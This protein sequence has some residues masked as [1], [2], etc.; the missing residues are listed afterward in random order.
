MPLLSLSM[1]LI[2]GLCLYVGLQVLSQFVLNRHSWSPDYRDL[3]FAFMSLMVVGYSGSELVAYHSQDVASYVSAFRWRGVFGALLLG[4]WPWFVYRYT[5]A[6]P[7]AVVWTLSVYFGLN[8]IVHLLRPYGSNFEAPPELIARV[9]PW[10]ER[11]SFHA[12]SQMN[13]LGALL[14][15][16]VM[17][18]VAYSY[19]ACYRQYRA[20]QRRAALKLA[21]AL[22]VFV[23]FVLENFFVRAGLLDFVF[24]AQ[25]GFPALILIMA[26][27][28]Q[29]EA[30]VRTERA[31]AE[32][33]RFRAALDCSADGIYLI[34]RARMRFLDCN[35]A[36]WHAL[37]Y[38]SREALLALGPHDI[39][40]E[41]SREQ[42]ASRFDAMLRG[43]DPGGV[44]ET[45]HQRTDGSTFPVEV[46]VRPLTTGASPL[47]VAVA[48]DITE[49]KR[50][51]S[52]LAQSEARHALFLRMSREGF[53]TIGPD[54]RIR[55]VNDAYCRML[56]FTRAEL[57]AM[58]VCDI[59]AAET[60]EEVEAHAATLRT[61]GNDLFET[62]Q[63][64]KDGTVLEV[65]VSAT[66]TEVSGE[67]LFMSFVRDI[68]PR[69]QAE[70][71]RLAAARAQRETL[72]R[73][74]HH[75]IKNN[76]QGVVGL[77][78]QHI[79]LNDGLRAPLEAT[80]GQVGSVA[81]VHGLQGRA[82]GDDIFLCELIEAIASA[83]AGLTGVAAAPRVERCV[84]NMITVTAEEAVPVA[85]ILNELVFNA[86]KHSSDR[87][88]PVQV[89]IRCDRQAAHV[90]IRNRGRP[91]PPDLSVT[92]GRGV[93]TGLNL[94][95]ALLP[96]QLG[97]LN[98]D[99]REG[100]VVVE[101]SLRPP[102]VVL[103]KEC[104]ASETTVV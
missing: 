75:R 34:D 56:G 10:G 77:L 38:T 80:I 71:E 35:R 22:T 84:G 8:L 20:G 90:Q 32:L 33:L 46:F 98:F 17:A 40:P 39:K 91:L 96:G 48:R 102:A 54:L 93:G 89:L 13:F 81:L 31:Q 95:H 100:W 41:F 3:L 60:P 12:T 1:A 76:L 4:A 103:P 2:M 87:S 7:S 50:A 36:A 79:Q 42:L 55:E 62:R 94:V 15:A 86:V 69:K 82:S 5:G 57:L 23:G 29:Q 16:G 43:E 19:F 68:T 21:F 70:R 53:M 88:V 51:E 92:V 30:H 99:Y 78:R 85:L 52:A 18:V 67:P 64:R 97:A 104:S 11:I 26:V 44:I 58:R 59:E 27:T 74:V 6:G 49:R 101:L 24:L 83:V 45:L 47:L 28:L 72:V 14:I 73:E 65:E 66:A 25:F 9:L 37:G 63:R 61:H